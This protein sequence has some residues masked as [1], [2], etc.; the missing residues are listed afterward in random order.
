MVVDD[1]PSLVAT[2]EDL[3]NQEGYVVEG[4]TNPVAALERLRNASLPDVLLSDCI[5][6]TLTG[7]ELVAALRDEGI[8]VP[9]V[10]MTALSDPSFCIHPGE[11][12]VINKPFDIEDLLAEIDARVR[13][14]RRR[15]RPAQPLG[16][17]FDRRDPLGLRLNSRVSPAA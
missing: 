3:L 10:L 8:D 7:G 9:V 16:R 11:I 5:M 6:P 1:D 14:A 2:L 15:R 4:F 12:H 17:G 13:P